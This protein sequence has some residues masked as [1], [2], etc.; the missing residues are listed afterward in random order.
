MARA[1]KVVI[2]GQAH[3]D[4]V[5]NMVVR[6]NFDIYRGTHDI[7]INAI[8]ISTG[9]N[10]E[11]EY[12]HLHISQAIYDTRMKGQAHIIVEGKEGKEYQVYLS[13]GEEKDLIED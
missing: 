13:T 4:V 10:I 5:L 7:I 8:S 12:S 3:D 9:A 2:N 6:E 1:I 11:D